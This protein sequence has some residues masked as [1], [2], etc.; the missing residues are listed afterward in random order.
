M[1]KTLTCLLAAAT[2]LTAPMAHAADKMLLKT[3]IAFSTALPGLGT[4][5]PRVAD[6]LATDRKSVV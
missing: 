2:M 3:P 1:K 4:P 6:A 5:I